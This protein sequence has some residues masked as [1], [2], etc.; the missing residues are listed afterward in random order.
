VLIHWL[1]PLN[2]RNLASDRVEFSPRGNFISGQNGQGKTNLLEAVYWLIALRSKRGTAQECVREGETGFHIEGDVSFGD[3]KHRV[4]LA[5]EGGSRRLLIDD[6]P[7]RRRRDYLEQVLV[8]DFF[9]EDLL[10]LMM[11]PVRRRRFLDLASVQYSL[12]QEDVLRRFKRLLEQRNGLLR[13]DK[14]P[15]PRVL[16]SFDAPLAESAAGVV[17]AR[18]SLLSRLNQRTRE[19]FREG[20]GEKHEAALEYVSSIDGVPPR[21]D[22][23]DSADESAFRDCYLQALRRARAVDI[24]ARRT[25]LGPHRD[26][27]SMSLDGKAVRTYG[28][29]GEVRSAMFA[30]HLA[31]FHVLVEK[32]GIEPVVLID[33]VMS[34]LDSSRRARVMELIPTGQVFLTACD[35]PPELGEIGGG[36]FRH[37]VIEGGKAKVLKIGA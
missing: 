10:I 21:V 1:R 5:V 36:E 9:P 14:A 12:P 15:D 18:L 31:R 27:W 19:I 7:P 3:L 37:F 34:E 29:R 13:A 8:V 11:E 32:R 2:Y 17:A 30:L 4:S 35:P 20:I 16:D 33:D 24:E 28:S 6:T 26:D 22:P 23:A 25:T